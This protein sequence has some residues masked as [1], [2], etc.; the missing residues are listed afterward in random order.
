MLSGPPPPSMSAAMSSSADCVITRVIIEIV[1]GRHRLVVEIEGMRIDDAD[2][3]I[4]RDGVCSSARH[5]RRRHRVRRRLTIAL[6]G[7]HLAPPLQSDFARHR[8]ARHFAHARDLD[9]ESI[10]RKQ[11]IAPSAGANSVAR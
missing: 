3:T 8:L 1:E 2:E 7:Q 10:K 11:R 9:V 6:A 5:Q 4:R